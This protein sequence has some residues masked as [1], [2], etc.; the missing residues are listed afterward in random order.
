MTKAGA[1]KRQLARHPPCPAPSCKG[2]LKH[3]RTH[4][5]CDQCGQH[6]IRPQA[7]PQE[8]ASSSA[9]DILIYGGAAGGGKSWAL[10]FEAARHIRVPGYAAIIFRRT[11]KQVTGGGS[12]WEEAS[13]LYPTL[14]GIGREHRLDWKF[15]TG[16]GER[17]STIEFGHLEHEKNKLDHQGKQYGFLGFDELTHFT[18]TQFWYLQTRARSTTGIRPRVWGTCNPDSESWVRRLIDWWIGDDGLPIAE[19]SGALRWFAR[20]ADDGGRRGPARRG[21][22]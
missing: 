12:I 17:P 5:R 7:G 20:G 1:A 3:R 21:G 13:S 10:T 16:D 15:G 9:A 6:S 18:E 8:R 4:W 2:R 19:R 11:T 22:R 14:G